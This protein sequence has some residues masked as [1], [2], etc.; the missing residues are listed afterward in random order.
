MK[1]RLIITLEQ[2]E[3]DAVHNQLVVRQ[4][5]SALVRDLLAEAIKA[6]NEKGGK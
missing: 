2:A 5:V 6:R 4:T 1:T 3:L